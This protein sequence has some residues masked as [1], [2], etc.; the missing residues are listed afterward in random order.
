[1]AEVGFA[2]DRPA[3]WRAGFRRRG[4]QTHSANDERLIKD[5]INEHP[6]S[7]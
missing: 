3:K 7:A 4:R 5:R 1:M 2:P 6:G